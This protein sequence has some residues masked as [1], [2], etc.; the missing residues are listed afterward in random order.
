MLAMSISITR[1][2]RKGG[3]PRSAN[4]IPGVFLFAGQGLEKRGKTPGAEATLR[5]GVRCLR[6]RV[7]NWRIHSA[8]QARRLAGMTLKMF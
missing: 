6:I 5:A 2:K 3:R 4:L 8:G 7:A 1:K